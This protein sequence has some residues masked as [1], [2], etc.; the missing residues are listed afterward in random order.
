M[1][2]LR[3]LPLNMISGG[4][5]SKNSAIHHHL[6]VDLT[7]SPAKVKAIRERT[8]VYMDQC[9]AE[10]GFM[11]LKIEFTASDVYNPPS[12]TCQTDEES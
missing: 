2:Q 9:L 7:I 10:S 5:E 11:L 8:A 6:Y 1:I 12:N 3:F 4:E